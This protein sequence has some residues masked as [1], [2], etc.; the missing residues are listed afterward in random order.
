[1][2]D[3]T[4]SV[5]LRVRPL[6]ENEIEKGCQMCLDIIPGEPQ[7]RIHNTDKAFTYNYVFPPNV[8][9]ED[10]YNIAIKRLLDNTFQGKHFEFYNFKKSYKVYKTVDFIILK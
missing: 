7:V 10:F 5:A 1:M 2:C 8:G 4:V 9:Q 3:D 6:V